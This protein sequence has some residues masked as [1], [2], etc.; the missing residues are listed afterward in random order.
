VPACAS[1]GYLKMFTARET[2][3]TAT[4]SEIISSA[5]H[6]DRRARADWR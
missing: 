4:T 5:I 6:P 1:P 2:T 3:S